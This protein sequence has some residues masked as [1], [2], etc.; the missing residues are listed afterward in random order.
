MI[1]LSSIKR[2][3]ANRYL[4]FV[5][6]HLSVVV[7]PGSKHAAM[8]RLRAWLAIGY[9]LYHGRGI[10]IYKAVLTYF[11]NLLRALGKTSA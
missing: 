3:R 10:S 7:A 5:M 1:A 8:A 4:R 11:A 6:P 9:G 2:T